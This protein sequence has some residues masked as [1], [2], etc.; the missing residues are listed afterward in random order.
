MPVVLAVTFW[1]AIGLIL[2]HLVGY[3]L[4]IYLLASAKKKQITRKEFLPFITVIIPAYN[5]GGVIKEKIN[6][7]LFSNYPANSIEILVPEDGSTD[8]TVEQVLSI[9]DPRVFLDHSH[10]RGGKMLAIN[11][12]VEQARGDFLVF[13]D[14]NAIF[15]PD[16]LRNLMSNFADPEVSCVCGRKLISGSSDLETNENVYWRYESWIKHNE[17]RLGS[18]PAAV[19]ELLAIRRDIFNLPSKTIINDD[20]QIALNTVEQGYRA[21]YDPTAVTFEKGSSSIQDE[22]G[23]KSRI[24]AGRWQVIGQV[25]K[26][27]FR[28]PWFVIA[29]FSHKMLRLF[30]FPL[31]ILAL[32]SN[33]GI[34]LLNLPTSSGLNFLIGLYSPWG[35]LAIGI[36]ALFYILAG[37]GAVLNSFGIRVRLLYLPYYFLYA[38][39]ASLSGFFR[40]SSGRQT[41]IW[42]KVAR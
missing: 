7:I 17:S 3:P 22:Y 27:A 25:V 37:T 9:S 12:A 15:K 8:N 18:T 23:R 10:S 24:A 30:V 42:R 35:Q 40:F 14:A 21:I 19:G 41:V 5:E 38:Q 33:L 34:V 1:L 29:F 28:R 20:F 32:C 31:M 16:T 39:I 11:R 4:L 6:S 13:T 2:Y 26:L 36:Q